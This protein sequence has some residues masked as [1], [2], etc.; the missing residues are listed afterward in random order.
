MKVKDFLD[1]LKAISH[2]PVMALTATATQRV[3]LDIQERL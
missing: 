1:E 3:K 2:F